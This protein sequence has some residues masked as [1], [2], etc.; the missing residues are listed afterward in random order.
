MVH[1]Q[2]D[3]CETKWNFFRWF[4]HTFFYMCV[5]LTLKKKKGFSFR[6]FSWPWCRWFYVDDDDD[7]V[8]DDYIDFFFVFI[9]SLFW[10]HHYHTNTTK[11]I[12]IIIIEKKKMDNVATIFV[13]IIK[14]N[15]LC[16]LHW[17]GFFVF[18]LLL[19]TL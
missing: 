3:L 12:I 13:L 4:R 2:S 18:S 19:R 5:L 8:N 15:V 16:F 10:H 11:I 14:K 17:K 9:R 6:F 7:D 1:F